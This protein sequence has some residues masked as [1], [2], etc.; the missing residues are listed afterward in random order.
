M[1]ARD[2]VGVEQRRSN[3]R[4]EG[5]GR[6]AKVFGKRGTSHGIDSFA[7]RVHS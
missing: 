5:R 3:I 4:A 1:R 2:G 7:M 6:S